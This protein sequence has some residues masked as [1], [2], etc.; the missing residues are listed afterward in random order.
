MAGR[1]TI[2]LG[3]VLLL[4]K[5]CPSN[6]EDGGLAARMI[7]TSP[8]TTFLHSGHLCILFNMPWAGSPVADNGVQLASEVQGGWLVGWSSDLQQTP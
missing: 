6:K 5:W 3:L 2:G 7:C 8:L 1:A 4:L